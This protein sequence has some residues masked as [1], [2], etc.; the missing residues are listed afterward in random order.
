MTNSNLSSSYCDMKSSSN[1]VNAQVNRATLLYSFL[2]WMEM[3]ISKRSGCFAKTLS[4][5]HNS[6]EEKYVL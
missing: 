1:N 6:H 4:F 3:Q 5:E 2:K